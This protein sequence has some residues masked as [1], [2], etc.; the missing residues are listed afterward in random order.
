MFDRFITA[1]LALI[2]GFLIWLYA[3]SREQETLDNVPVPVQITLPA[4][5]A[6][7][8]DLEATGP[9]V[10]IASFSG[11]PS[12]MRE[13]RKLLQAGELQVE[14][15]LA[16]PED[17]E[18]ASRY[19]DTIRI[20][21][22]DI[23]APPGVRV[24]VTEGRNRIPVTLRLL[25]ERSLPVRL[26]C[27]SEENC[28]ITLE[29]ACVLVRG[30]Q[31]ILDRLRAVPTEPFVLPSSPSSLD[32]GWPQVMT[33]PSLP[34]VKELDGRPVRITP[35]VVKARITVKPRQKIHELVDVPVHFLCPPSFGLRPQWVDE[36]AGKIS[37]RVQGPAGEEAP[38]VSAFVDL[39]G[40]K[41]EAGLYAEEPLRLQLPK[42]VQLSQPPPRSGAFRLSPI[43]PERGEGL[44]GA[45]PA[46]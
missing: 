14:T 4:G 42:D 24:M 2:L 46:P 7:Q 6:E 41:L 10:V 23:H 35:G 22:A 31:E 44:R 25:T 5:K 20:E 3:R 13:L 9:S 26:E 11:P 16:M 45:V 30:P 27:A 38:A 15:T 18:P 19:L 21:A 32:S 28:Q 39:T 43:P 8:Y 33:V 12:R 34:L 29:P 36:R 1:L 37:L 40:K 17:R